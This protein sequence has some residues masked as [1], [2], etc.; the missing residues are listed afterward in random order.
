MGT[1]RWSLALA[2][3]LAVCAPAFADNPPVEVGGDWYLSGSSVT[4]PVSA[5][6]DVLA[7]GGSV[8][9]TQDVAQDVHA[10]GLDVEIDG[11]VLGDA[12]ASGASVSVDGS[13]AG[14]LTASALILRTGP[15][16]E[17]GGNARLAAMTVT[18]EGPVAGALVAAGAEV[19][20]NAPVAGDVSLSGMEINFGPNARIDGQ[21]TY[22]STARVDIPEGVISA[23]RVRFEAAN[24]REMW[25][26]VRGDWQA[27]DG[28]V[29]LSPWVVIGGFLINLGLFV[30]LG[31]VLLA[32]APNT[33]RRLRRT[34]DARPGMVILTG[35]I[36]LSIL[37]G[38]LLIGAL[39]VVGLP[40]LPIIVL[41]IVLVWLLGYLLGA[42]VLAMRVL[43]GLGTEES[44]GMAMRLLALAIGVTLVALLNFI[45]VLGWMANFAL[46]LLGVGAITTALFESFLTGVAADRDQALEPYEPSQS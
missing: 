30:L 6:R 4:E 7:F 32:L 22:Y 34:A 13:V 11:A 45:P 14:D 40:L 21:L 42:Y 46:V 27:W 1:Y 43:R 37:F 12:V 15:G 31:A 8:T 20:L 2:G 36:G 28:P 25:R 16:A 24:R 35:A 29:E 3:F 10:M 44:P 23:D 9:V 33:V 17:I 38:S 39:S 5:G 19:T 26:D 18:V 41:L